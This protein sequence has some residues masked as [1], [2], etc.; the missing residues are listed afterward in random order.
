M[1]ISRYAARSDV[2]LYNPTEEIKE[3]EDTGPLNSLF[4]RGSYLWWLLDP[5]S[6]GLAEFGENRYQIINWLSYTLGHM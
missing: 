3:F 4:C 1:P 6:H 5:R 2:P